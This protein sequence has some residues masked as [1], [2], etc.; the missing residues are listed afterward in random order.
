M[1]VSGRVCWQIFVSG[2]L[3]LQLRLGLWQEDFDEFYDKLFGSQ[4][5]NPTKGELIMMS[6]DASVKL[7]RVDLARVFT[8]QKG[9]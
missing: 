8:C 5:W 4:N 6:Y 7:A 3:S 9:S 1:L 2:V